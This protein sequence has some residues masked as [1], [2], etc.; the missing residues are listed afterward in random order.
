MRRY[1]TRCLDCRHFDDICR[2]DGRVVVLCD[3]PGC[4]FALKRERNGILYRVEGTPGEVFLAEEVVM[5]VGQT[6]AAVNAAA[7]FLAD[8]H[9]EPDGQGRAESVD[10][11]S[12]NC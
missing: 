2:D 7:T 11:A 5:R 6:V 10:R 8:C 3:L 1:V 9:R 12:G 4:Q